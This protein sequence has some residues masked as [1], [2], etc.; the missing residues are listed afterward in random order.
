MTIEYE[1]E[2]GENVLSAEGFGWGSERMRESRGAWEGFSKGIVESVL[3]SKEVFLE[4]GSRFGDAKQG[5]DSRLNWTKV[6][7][8]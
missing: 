8:R 2:S 1:G 6:R 5:D 7:I 4:G 3:F